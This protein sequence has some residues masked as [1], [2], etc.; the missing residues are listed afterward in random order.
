MVGSHHAESSKLTPSLEYELAYRKG[1]WK[2]YQ[3]KKGIIER[4]KWM[5]KRNDVQN[6]RIYKY[7]KQV[8]PIASLGN[9]DSPLTIT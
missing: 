6:R 7:L 2:K 4:N 9:R 1:G 3:P 5:A 8:G